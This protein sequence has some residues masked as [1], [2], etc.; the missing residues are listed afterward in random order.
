MRIALPIAII[1][2]VFAAA[3]AVAQDPIPIG[4]TGDSRIYSPGQ[5]GIN[6]TTP[7]RIGASRREMNRGRAA[8][9]RANMTPTMARNY[10]EQAIA[11]AG[12][13]CEVG[14]SVVLGQTRDGAPLVEVDCLNGGGLVIADSNPI[15]AS[16]CLDLSPNEAVVGRAS[17]RIESCRLP[18]NVAAV[19]ATRAAEAPQDPA[20]N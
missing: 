13:R 2:V 4:P 6:A 20:R 18:A 19:N 8:A 17:I 10:A 1:G 11:R 9:W 7:S 3:P 16:D 12:F 15:V 14:E 5:L